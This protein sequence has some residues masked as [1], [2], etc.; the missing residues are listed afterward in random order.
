MT[1]FLILAPYGAFSLLMLVTSATASVLAAAAICLMVI[2]FDIVRGRSIKILGAGSVVVFAAIGGYLA[3]VDPALSTSAVKFSVDTGI[4]L[5]SLAV[6][7]R[8]A[9]RSPCNMRWRWSMPRPRRCLV[10]CARTTSSPGPGPL[11]RS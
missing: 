2:A 4:F 8:S 5:V 9:I 11:R 1:I 10:S 3:L 6:D 7:R